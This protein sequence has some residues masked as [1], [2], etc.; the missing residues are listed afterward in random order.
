MNA[1]LVYLSGSNIEQDDAQAEWKSQASRLLR[2]KNIMSVTAPKYRGTAQIPKEPKIEVQRDKTD[3]MM[4][5]AFLAKCDFPSFATSMQI[6]FAWSLQK[7][8]ILVTSSLS[9]WLQFHASAIFPTLEDAIES[10]EF[11]PLDPKGEC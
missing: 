1:R 9:P 11:P 3:I 6:M 4:A 2:K 7:K 8:I 10:L 5:D